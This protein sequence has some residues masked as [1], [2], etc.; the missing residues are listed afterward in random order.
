MTTE[1]R[2][3]LAAGGLLVL[4]A[5]P[6]YAQSPADDFNRRQEAQSQAQRLDA[7]RQATPG[8]GAAT[9]NG[10]LP[11]G[12]ATGACFDIQRVEIDGVTLLSS[13]G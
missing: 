3:F 9:E 8:G 12:E 13:E 1:I 2:C 10:P 7:L 4:G 6:T 5:I 11:A